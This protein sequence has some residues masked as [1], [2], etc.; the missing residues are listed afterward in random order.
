MA[1]ERD[2]RH[3]LIIDLVI[4]YR[5][6]GHDDKA[7]DLKKRAAELQ[8][9]RELTVLANTCSQLLNWIEKK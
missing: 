5:D 1:E 8:T 2:P 9:E 3:Q 7:D 6:A 4:A